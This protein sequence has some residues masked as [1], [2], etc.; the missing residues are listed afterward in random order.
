MA[1]ASTGTASLC[2]SRD[3][4]HRFAWMDRASGGRY[5][6]RVHEAS[7]DA[8]SLGAALRDYGVAELTLAQEHL[9]LRGGSVHDGIHQARKAIRRARAMLALAGAALGPGSDFVDRGLR[10]ANRR[11]SPL[12]DAQALVEVLDRLDTKARN[13]ETRALLA[14][15]RHVAV[16]RRAAFAREAAFKLILHEQCSVLAVLQAALQGLPWEAVTAPGLTAAMGRTSHR[17]DALRERAMTHDHAED[18]HRWR[19]CMRRLSQQHRAA[20]AAGLVVPQSE[21][22]KHLTEQLGVLQDLSL[23]IAHCQGES[24]FSSATRVALR[25]FAERSLARQ[26]KRIRSVLPRD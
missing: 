21:F 22:D 18:W 1:Q 7:T 4:G 5:P 24:P 17:A 10:R 12:R 11:L 16:R 23:L 25:A 26:R 19:R 13:D 14:H 2:R 8:G 6:D 15:A 9:A 20:V 3:G